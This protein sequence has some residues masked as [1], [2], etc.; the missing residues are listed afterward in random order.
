MPA[1]PLP[2]IV[3]G[4]LAF[5][6]LHL[7]RRGIRERWLL[8]F[9]SGCCA[10][11]ALVGLRWGIDPT[12]VRVLQP[13]LASCLPVLAWTALRVLYEGKP[14]LLHWLWPPAILV[15]WLLFP[16]AVDVLLVTEFFLYGLLIFRLRR[17]DDLLPHVRIG[18]EWTIPYIRDGVAGF[19]VLSAIVDTVVAFD[20]SAGDGAL[21]APAVAAMTGVL[22]LSMTAG[23]LALAGAAIP[24]DDGQ[25]SAAEPA[26]L[27]ALLSEEEEETILA[28]VDEILAGGLYRDYD[29]TLQRLSRRLRIPARKISQAVN[30]KRAQT[31][32]DL[33]NAYRVQEAM[34][35]LRD[36]DLSVTQVMLEAGFQTKSNFNRA[37]R[38]IAGR[39]PSEYRR[40]ET[41]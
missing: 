15:S 7:I 17:L 24:A 6:I 36:S 33:V 21:A 3:T 19:L 1:I 2:F 11:S 14:S 27:P 34:R 41:G 22:L 12:W 16:A 31:V 23:L 35:L 32:T 18:D 5:V 39:T 28:R 29:L 20:M 37:F 9:L 30:R 13:L 4:V 10:Q 8:L 38:E 25:A 26:P 40:S